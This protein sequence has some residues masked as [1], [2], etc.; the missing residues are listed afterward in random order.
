MLATRNRAVQAM[1]MDEHDGATPPTSSYRQHQPGLIDCESGVESPVV[2]MGDVWR[3]KMS[4]GIP[5]RY[6]NTRALESDFLINRSDAVG[7]GMNGPVF[8]ATSYQDDRQYAVKSFNKSGLAPS[9]RE[10]LRSEVENYIL[11]D[12]PHIARLE[13]VYET[14]E[15]IHL[16]MEYMAGGELYDRLSKST[17]YS[18]QVSVETTRQILLAVAYLHAQGMVH[19]D[20]KL[21][22]FLYERA[23][24]D[25]LKLIDFGFTVLWDRKVNMSKACGSLH[26]VAP[27][28]LN[29]SYTEKAD[30][31]SVGVIV[32]MLL[33]G[34]P[35]FS[36]AHHD[37]IKAIRAGRITDP[38][39]FKG[40]SDEARTFIQSL[41]VVDASE[42]PSAA[43]VLEHPWLTKGAV[44]GCS[45]ID[46]STIKSMRKF[47]LSSRFRKACFCMMAWSLSLEDRT[48]LRNQFLEMDKE[49]RGTISLTE[50]KRVIEENYYL[51]NKETE[52]IF[53]SLD[54]DQ[55]DCICYSEF[56]AAMIQDRVQMHE[57]LLRKTFARFD[58]DKT[59]KITLANLRNVFR[60]DIVDGVPLD[61][62][63]KEADF[64]E[65]GEI[66]YDDFLVY[67]RSS[68]PPEPATP[69]P[70]SVRREAQTALA[71]HL[72]DRCLAEG[73][74]EPTPL[75]RMNSMR[76]IT[77]KAR[78]PVG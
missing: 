39:S 5:G 2:K 59:G 78:R 13:Q 61:Q 46:K 67:L 19:R 57:T 44:N 55:D 1:G 74:E 52:A 72:I 4:V 31:W 3:Q 20:L 12:H 10:S 24:N 54:A 38:R 33:T 65:D 22:N 27:E 40:V 43:Q 23:D 47:A 30:M 58:T 71:V 53:N 48:R 62:L 36:G 51:D 14:T 26:Y 18:E 42:R 56:L 63:I 76:L 17:K 60:G 21:E 15:E 50:F 73:E 49:K 34:S 66:C 45:V 35:P 69:S 70:S 77:P 7:T 9:M 29:H 6:T 8:L 75:S 11:L 41:L 68:E 25:V 37:L 16:V 32:Y 64:D 28:V